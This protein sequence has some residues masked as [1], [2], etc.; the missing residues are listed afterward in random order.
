MKYLEGRK[1]TVG[2]CR[3][4]SVGVWW[5]RLVVFAVEKIDERLQQSF[6]VFAAVVTELDEEVKQPQHLQQPTAAT[7]FTT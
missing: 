3:T 6:D 7:S 2:K 5:K 1:Y 4:A